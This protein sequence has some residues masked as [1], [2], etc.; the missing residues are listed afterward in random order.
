MVIAWDYREIRGRLVARDL[1]SGLYRV[2]SLDTK[3]YSTLSL[4]TRGGGT[5]LYGLYGD[6]PMVRV[7]FLA[8][9]S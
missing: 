6:V 7:W 2:V 4:S 5:L 9:L 1:V 8:S 3:L